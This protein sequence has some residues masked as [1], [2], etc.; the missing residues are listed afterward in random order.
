MTVPRVPHPDERCDACDRHF[1]TGD[2]WDGRHDIDGTP[3]HPQCCPNPD[4]VTGRAELEA[5]VA[6]TDRLAYT[7]E[8]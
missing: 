6:E 7:K 5:W 1:E 2:E 3:Y 8:R 4:C